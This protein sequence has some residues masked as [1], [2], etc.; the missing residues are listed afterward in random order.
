MSL[1]PPAGDGTEP[2][3]SKS[4]CGTGDGPACAEVATTPDA[5]RV[6]DPKHIP[7]PRLPFGPQHGAA[8]LSYASEH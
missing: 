4:G 6:R 2:T 8:F 7:G 5:I 3:W 1:K